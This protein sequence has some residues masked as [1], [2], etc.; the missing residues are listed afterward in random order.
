VQQDVLQLLRINACT[1]RAF[2]QKQGRENDP[3]SAGGFFRFPW[4]PFYSGCLKGLSL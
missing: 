2:F 1:P 3:F 4:Q